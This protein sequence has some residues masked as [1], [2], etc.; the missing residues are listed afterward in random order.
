MNIIVRSLIS[1]GV[2]FI[3]VLIIYLVFINKKRKS[4][5]EG[6][7]YPE[8]SYLVNKF[9]LDIKKTKYK[10]LCILTSIINSFIIAFTFALIIN[11]KYKYFFKLLISFVIMF[12]LIYS[13][14][15]I[16]GRILKKI[17]NKK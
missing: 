11:L 14:Y 13:L 12:I 9:K 4:Y 1:F 17:E 8:I 15:E 10:K 2:C 3:V 16:T 5:E 6:K 7:D